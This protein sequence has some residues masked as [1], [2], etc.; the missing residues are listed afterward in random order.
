MAYAQT[1][2]L[3]TGDTR[4]VLTLVLRDSNEPVE[5]VTLDPNDP[6][7]WATI[8]LSGST[9]ALRIRAIGEVGFSAT[10]ACV[11]VDALQGKVLATFTNG[12][13]PEAGQYEGE[14]EITYQDGGIQTVG[15]LIKFKV[16]ASFD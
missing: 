1:I 16:R 2:N 10:A 3:V 11:V 8:D 12:T 5:G 6:L 7:T 15:D 9:V 13:F 14:I 4:P